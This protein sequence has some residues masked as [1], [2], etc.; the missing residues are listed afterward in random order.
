MRPKAALS[1]RLFIP[2]SGA[3]TAKI[4]ADDLTFRRVIVLAL[5]EATALVNQKHPL[6]NPF[7]LFGFGG[8]QRTP[9]PERII[10][11]PSASRRG[12]GK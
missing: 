2:Q 11:F 8:F 9:T 5:Q 10:D 6:N 1:K 3:T 7:Q 12:G 4:D